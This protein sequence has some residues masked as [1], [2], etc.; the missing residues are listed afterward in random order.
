[1]KTKLIAVAFFV[2]VLLAYTPLEMV[3]ILNQN[4]NF[5]YV[6][7]AMSII[8]E[9]NIDLQEFE[10]PTR[11]LAKEVTFL[12]DYFGEDDYRIFRTEDG[13]V[14]NHYPIGT[15]LACV[16]VVG[17]L[18]LRYGNAENPVWSAM[19]MAVITAKVYAAA[20]V[21]L[22]YLLVFRLV[23][24]QRWA[25][26]L[27][28]VL[29]FSSLNF[30]QHAGGLWSH[31][32]AAFYVVLALLCVVHPRS[33]LVWLS[34]FPLVFAVTMRPDVILL[35]AILTVYIWVTHRP[36]FLKFAVVGACGAIAYVA[37]CKFNFN[38]FTQ[39]YPGPINVLGRDF[40]GGLFGLLVS[41][42]R[43]LLIYMPLCGLVV[44]GVIVAFR[45]KE[46]PIIYRYFSVAVLAHWV[47][48]AVWPMWWAGWCYGPRLFCTMIPIWMLLLL[49]IRRG[50]ERPVMLCVLALMIFW[51]SFVQ[52]RCLSD[53]DV[54]LWN[55]MPVD[56]NNYTERLWDW[57][58]LQIT[59]GIGGDYGIDLPRKRKPEDFL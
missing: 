16:P 19:W 31:N 44:G 37:F 57:S 54:H 55:A 18:N 21:A 20:T 27:A 12:K 46:T 56:V 1:M 3:R 51:G 23:N 59:R 25:I 34:A 24:E 41:P 10:A 2:G 58:D 5:W 40:V 17:F 49:P 9:G 35:I 39:P 32:P 8:N 6:P 53:Q 22:F 43:G 50:L 11:E 48:L 13:R 52:I 36:A 14:L 29:G 45:D 4:D 28:L 26:G 7:T 30:G 42:N 15:S 38:A 33:N 47:F